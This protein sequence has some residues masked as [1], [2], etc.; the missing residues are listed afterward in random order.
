LL[1]PKKNGKLLPA[2]IIGVAVVHCIV[3]VIVAGVIQLREWIIQRNKHQGPR[4]IYSA[5]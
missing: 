3:F 1:D 2:Y 5:D 4:L